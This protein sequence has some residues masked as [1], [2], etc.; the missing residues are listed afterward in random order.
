[1]AQTHHA[2]VKLH[3]A[4]I[5]F[6]I[7]GLFGKLIPID[8]SLIVFGRTLIGSIV[9]LLVMTVT[10]K[11]K[12]LSMTRQ[13]LG[14][15]ALG[16]ILSFHWITFFHS[17]QVSSVAIGLL[18]FSSSPVFV[19]LLEPFFYREKLRKLD[20]ATAMGVVAGISIIFPFS[21]IASESG[22]VQGIIWGVMSALLLA[23]LSLA[24]RSRVQ[25][26][27][28]M[29]LTCLQNIGAMVTTLLIIPTSEWRLLADFS[30]EV[31]A[32]GLI[33]T[34]LP[35]MLFLISLRHIKAQLVSLVLCLEPVYGIILAAVVLSEIPSLRTLLGGA[36]I[37][38]AITVGTLSSRSTT[39]H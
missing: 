9:L 37:L 27:D 33:C 39:A 13:T 31:I 14:D 34:T 30:V 22:I 16:S 10:G 23:L 17:I 7:S 3:I 35:L 11:L 15:M 25:K 29:E 6:G 5:L 36:V 18:A 32:L 1:M 19:T 4:V 2:L 26:S 24:N 12:S 21:S 8:P 20:L 28:P 38:I